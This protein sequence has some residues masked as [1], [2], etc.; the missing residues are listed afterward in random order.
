MIG[1]VEI[2]LLNELLSSPF[3]SPF[4]IL[5]SSRFEAPVMVM[6]VNGILG[7]VLINVGL[8]VELRIE[9]FKFE[10]IHV[11]CTFLRIFF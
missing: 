9:N 5:R 6:H 1:L 11:I 10:N 4:Q 3:L 7:L 8:L 2:W